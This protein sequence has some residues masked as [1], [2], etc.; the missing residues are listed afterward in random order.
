[1]IEIAQI[2][3]Q[4]GEVLLYILRNTDNR[5]LPAGLSPAHGILILFA[6]SCI[7]FALEKICEF[8]SLC[9]QIPQ[10]HNQLF[11]RNFLCLFMEKT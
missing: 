4:I 2:C 8:Q 7:N 1:M 3:A 6:V 5:G 11:S 10:I 9:L